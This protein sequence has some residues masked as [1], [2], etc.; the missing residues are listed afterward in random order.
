M[1]FIV[2]VVMALGCAGSALAQTTDAEHATAKEHENFC[3]SRRKACVEK[4]KWYR[5]HELVHCRIR[6]NQCVQEIYQSNAR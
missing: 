3:S 4:N 5:Q 1:K 6:Y 2:A